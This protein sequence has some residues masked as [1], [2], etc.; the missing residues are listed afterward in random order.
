MYSQNFSLVQTFAEMCPDFSKEVFTVW[1]FAEQMHDFLTTP[2]PVDGHA[3]HAKWQNEEANL[4]NNGLVFLLCAGLHNYENIRT[5]IVGKKL[6]CWTEGF[7]TADSTSTTLEHLLHILYSSRLIFLNSS[8]LEDRQTVESHLV[9]MGTSLYQCTHIM[10][11]SF[12]CS[13]LF[14]ETGLSV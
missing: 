2:L 5:A 9:H 7:S 14:A 1:I 10:T 12:S 13:F 6:A 11:S 8:H 3:P 4:C